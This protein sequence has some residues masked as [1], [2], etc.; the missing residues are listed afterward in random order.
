MIY[1]PVETTIP[2]RPSSIGLFILF[3]AM[4]LSPVLRA[5]FAKES[6]QRYRKGSAL[7]AKHHPSHYT[8]ADQALVLASVGLSFRNPKNISGT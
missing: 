1:V 3:W 4:R 7:A 8:Q 6:G 2:I 5:E